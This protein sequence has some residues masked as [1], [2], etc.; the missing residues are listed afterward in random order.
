MM[1]RILT[2]FIYQSAF[3]S[4]VSYISFAKEPYTSIATETDGSSGKSPS[5]RGQ[6]AIY[7][8]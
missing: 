7:P 8:L 3:I 5:T 4:I 1:V 2:V 6:L